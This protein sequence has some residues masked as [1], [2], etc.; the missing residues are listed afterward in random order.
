MHIHPIVGRI[1]WRFDP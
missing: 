1:S